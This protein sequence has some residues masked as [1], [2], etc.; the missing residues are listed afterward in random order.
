MA[1]KIRAGAELV[2]TLAAAASVVAQDGMRSA[3]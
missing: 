3:R 2:Q 1:Q